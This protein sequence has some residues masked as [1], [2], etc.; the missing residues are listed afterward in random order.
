MMKVSARNQLNGK[1]TRIVTGAVNNEVD[2]TLE[3]GEV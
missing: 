2:I 3:H 1:V